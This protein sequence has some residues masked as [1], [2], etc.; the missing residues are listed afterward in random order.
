MQY[1]FLTLFLV[2]A[3]G[4]GLIFSDKK[5]DDNA[6]E[7][8]DAS[9]IIKNAKYFLMWPVIIEIIRLCMLCFVYRIES[10]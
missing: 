4:E 6:K 10:P 7:S 1:S 8:K 2:L 5:K 3:S 9:T